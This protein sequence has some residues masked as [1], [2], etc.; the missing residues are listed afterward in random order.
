MDPNS[1]EKSLPSWNLRGTSTKSSG[2]I[3]ILVGFDGRTIRFNA[4][5]QIA[6]KYSLDCY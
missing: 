3:Q 1:S 2:S 5:F 6:S 4:D